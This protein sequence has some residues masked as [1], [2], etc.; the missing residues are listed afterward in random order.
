[1]SVGK[2]VLK[3]NLAKD[4]KV[5]YKLKKNKELWNFPETPGFQLALWNLG[6]YSTTISDVA[7]WSTSKS[8]SELST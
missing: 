3:D 2:V 7:K 4:N 8:S 6:S 1:M 5:Y